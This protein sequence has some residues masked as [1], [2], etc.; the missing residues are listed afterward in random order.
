MKM[1]RENGDEI[2][3]HDRGAGAFARP[4]RQWR[5]VRPDGDGGVVPA[6]PGPDELLH[7]AVQW[8]VLGDAVE[9]LP[10]RPRLR[11]RGDLL[12]DQHRAG[13]LWRRGDLAR[14]HR[15]LVE[16]ELAGP[17]A[18]LVRLRG[19]RHRDRIDLRPA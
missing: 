11:R 9:H 19:D 2:K 18:G 16:P 5:P 1:S 14:L 7:R 12:P 10:V 17:E 13:H 15:A 4:G 3:A 6:W 8:R